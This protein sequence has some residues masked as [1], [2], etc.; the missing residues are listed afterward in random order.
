MCGSV[1]WDSGGFYLIFFYRADA[2][3]CAV[4]LAAAYVNCLL[5]FTVDE[6][7]C[8]YRFI[9]DREHSHTH[10]HTHTHTQTQTHKHRDSTHSGVER[11]CI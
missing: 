5:A 3:C 9:E 8:T 1:V 10:A 11:I 4:Y 7:P 6:A 2:M